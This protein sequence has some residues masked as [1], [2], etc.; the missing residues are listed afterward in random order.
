MRQ[1]FLFLMSAKIYLLGS[2]I[3]GTTLS[4]QLLKAG[5][6]HYVYDN[7]QHSRS[8]RIAAGLANPVVLKRQ[9]WVNKAELFMPYARSFYEHF[10][11]NSGITI[12][13]DAQ[14][15]HIFHRAG[16]ANDWQINSTKPL[17]GEHLGPILKEAI[18]HIDSPHFRGRLENIFWLDTQSYIE[19]HKEDLRQKERLLE[20]DWPGMDH[21]G[22]SD[23][24]I[25]CNGHLLRQ[26]HPHLEKAFSPTKG[27]LMIIENTQ[28]PTDRILHAGVFTLP[29]A[30]GRFKVGASYAHQ[31]INDESSAKGLHFL[32]E[33]LQAFYHGPYHISE[34]VAGVRPNIKDRKPL[35]GK[36]NSREYVFNGMGSR[37][38][39]M[40]PY[41][42]QHFIEF[43]LQAKALEKQWD[44]NRFI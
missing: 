16:E 11:K 20:A 35:L 31:N 18:P 36:I 13:H 19:K 30:Q 10:E 37:G 39:L 7:P 42:A 12:K 22:P 41:L 27:E 26:S 17:L 44:L 4:I 2:G 23:R 29:L 8:S 15:E 3:A 14:I 32:E 28:L 43:F 34:Q 9:K 38:V 24:V 1:G 25:Y 40:A 5:V 6:D 21:L 33:K